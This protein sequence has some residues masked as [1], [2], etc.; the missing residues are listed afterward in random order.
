MLEMKSKWMTNTLAKESIQKKDFIV[1]YNG[2][3]LFIVGYGIITSGGKNTYNYLIKDNTKDIVLSSGENA[4]L[5][6]L[7]KIVLG[8]SPKSKANKDANESEANKPKK[9]T[10]KQ[11]NKES[12]LLTFDEAFEKACNMMN[13]HYEIKY[14]FG[15]YSKNATIDLTMYIQH[16]AR[17]KEYARIKEAKKQEELKALQGTLEMAIAQGN[18]MLV[19]TIK[20]MIAN[21]EKE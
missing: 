19:D 2:T 5:D 4:Y 7:T 16:E 10:S 13:E 3:R 11:A 21:K 8:A 15:K 12:F 20:E 1:C 17:R 14:L 18:T 6:A 9:Q